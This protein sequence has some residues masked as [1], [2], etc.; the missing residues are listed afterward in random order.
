RTTRAQPPYNWFSA[1]LDS[2]MLP[3]VQTPAP[4]DVTRSV[5][6]AT[7]TY[8]SR[9]LTDTGVTWPAVTVTSLPPGACRSAVCLGDASRPVADQVSQA[10]TTLP[11][12]GRAS[13]ADAE[14]F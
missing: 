4:P 9:P 13:D 10:R 1:A 3:A 5:T 12:S 14:L 2:E 6:S 8:P 11:S 7:A